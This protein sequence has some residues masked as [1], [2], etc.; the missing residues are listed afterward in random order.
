[1]IIYVRPG[2]A[3]WIWST[4]IPWFTYSFSYIYFVHDL[5]SIEPVPVSFLLRAGEENLRH[6]AEPPEARVAD[7][8]HPRRAE[9]QVGAGRRLR[10]GSAK[11]RR[12]TAGDHRVAV[13]EPSGTFV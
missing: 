12:Q 3:E 10:L 8:Q 4:I 7:Q 2:V 9:G 5:Y 13:G 11:E 1:M 6:G